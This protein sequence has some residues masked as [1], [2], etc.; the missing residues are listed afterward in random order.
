MRDLLIPTPA[1]WYCP[2]GDF[3]IDPRQGVNRAIITHAHS[4]HARRG[5][6]HYL[7]AKASKTLLQQR[8]GR[9]A[10][11]ETLRYGEPLCLNGVRISLHPA[12]HILGSA[13][14]RLEYGGEVWVVSG[15]YKLQPDPTCEPFEPLRCDVFL[16]ECTFGLP[17][18][19]WPPPDQ[20]MRRLESWWQDNQS[21]G[22]TSIVLAYSIG[23]AQRILASLRPE[24]GPI[25]VHPTI[26]QHLEA[27]RAAGVALPTVRR[28]DD[29]MA[30]LQK[31]RCL[32]IAPPA[33]R[34]SHWWW[35]F[36]PC[37]WSWAS[38][39]VLRV[40]QYRLYGQAANHHTP[41]C[42]VGFVL[43]DHADWPGLQRAVEM[44]GARTVW[45]THGYTAAFA[46]WLRKSG[47]TTLVL[48]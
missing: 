42:D 45:V 34:R 12:G 20:E 43:S 2:I 9:R 24:L 11:I 7:A 33:A 44:T 27:Y 30:L 17:C 8:L 37:A 5:C 41:A 1:G 10:A 40:P 26:A 19:C 36:R 13:Q 38:G 18:Y 16:T 6:R 23:K 31:G 3:Y 28:T 46:A 4:D 15:D 47:R 39:W 21:Q 29:P 22:V 25:V 32:I 14:V 48:E 35:P